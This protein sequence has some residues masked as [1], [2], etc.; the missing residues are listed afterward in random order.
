MPSHVLPIGHPWRGGELD[1]MLAERRA[2]V[3]GIGKHMKIRVPDASDQLVVPSTPSDSRAEKN[4]ISALKHLLSVVKTE[5][6]V[7]ERREKKVTHE[8]HREFLQGL[9]LATR[10][11]S[12]SKSNSWRSFRRSC[13]RTVTRLSSS[14]PQRWKSSKRPSP[15]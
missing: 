15:R 4:A 9:R 14:L 3:I 7:G 8:Q 11:R 6:T 12:P 1:R 10:R 2:E 5:A 13:S